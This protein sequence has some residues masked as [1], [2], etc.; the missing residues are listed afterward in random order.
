[1]KTRIKNILMAL[2]FVGLSYGALFTNVSAAYF[3][4]S[5]VAHCGGYISRSLSVGSEN[6]DVFALQEILSDMG[7]LQVVT[8]M[9]WP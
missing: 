7:Y 3:N 1:M 6:D 9:S 5:P 2:G 4:A 8:G